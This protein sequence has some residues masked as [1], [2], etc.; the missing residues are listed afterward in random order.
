MIEYV[1]YNDEIFYIVPW[2]ESYAL[3]NKG[4]LIYIDSNNNVKFVRRTNT[5]F[6][7]LKNDNEILIIRQD[8]LLLDTF[9]GH[10][11]LPIKYK[12]KDDSNMKLRNIEYDLSGIDLGSLQIC[13]VEFKTIPNF[14][15][16]AISSNGII[17]NKRYRKLMK[18]SYDRQGYANL[19]LIS[20][21]GKD[22]HCKIHC[23]MMAAWIGPRPEGMV[24]HHKDSK[25]YHNELYNI[26]YVTQ[27]DNIYESFICGDQA[28]QI[29]RSPNDVKYICSLINK[30]FDN[31]EILDILNK[32]G[33]ERHAYH[34]ALNDIRSKRTWKQISDLYF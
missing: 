14:T 27:A 8:K 13:G 23:L 25:E 34:V 5:G 10:I 6:Y 16:Y 17:L 31:G 7:A 4:K 22:V 11:D 30:G 20:D 24:V 29:K 3:S 26:E 18:Y 21:D 19:H 2:F 33:E 9:V 12:D 28:M 1:K 15:R 32:Y